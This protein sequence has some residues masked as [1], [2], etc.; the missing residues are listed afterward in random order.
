M[1][2]TI[3]EIITMVMALDFTMQCQGHHSQ[4][5]DRELDFTIK[6]YRIKEIH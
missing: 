2:K 1:L 6:I 3:K 4:D 5:V